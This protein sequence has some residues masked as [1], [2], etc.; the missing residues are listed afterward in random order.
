MVSS[1]CPEER[2]PHTI[3]FLV[4]IPIAQVPIK[5]E[6]ETIPTPKDFVPNPTAVVA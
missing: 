1:P 6:P 3:S 4:P 5:I 2:Y